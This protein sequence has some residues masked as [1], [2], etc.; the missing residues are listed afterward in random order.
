M[1]ARWGFV[2]CIGGIII[3]DI[4]VDSVGNRNGECHLGDVDG[5]GGVGG[6]IMVAGC[7]IRPFGAARGVGRMSCRFWVAGRFFAVGEEWV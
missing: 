3:G 4:G 1:G 7:S 6:G 5:C 2:R